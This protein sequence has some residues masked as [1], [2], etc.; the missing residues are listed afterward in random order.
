MRF[1]MI[2]ISRLMAS[3]YPHNVSAVIKK[4]LEKSL[5]EGM[6]FAL[7]YEVADVGCNMVV[8]AFAGKTAEAAFDHAWSQMVAPL[9]RL[10]RLTAKQKFLKIHAGGV[11]IFGFPIP[12]ERE[13]FREGAAFLVGGAE[14]KVFQES[15]SNQAQKVYEAFNQSRVH[16]Y[17]KPSAKVNKSSFNVKWES[18]EQVASE[19]KPLTEIGAYFFFPGSNTSDYLRDVRSVLTLNGHCDPG[20]ADL[21]SKLDYEYFVKGYPG[22]LLIIDA[23]ALEKG[24]AGLADIYCRPT[25]CST[26]SSRALQCLCPADREAYVVATDLPSARAQFLDHRLAG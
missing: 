15:A 18:L 2:S 23:E 21:I 22:D 25:H 11:N 26:H 5:S 4:D 12:V 17:D 19:I 9:N 16:Y 3:G 14:F 20:L 13:R 7:F 1:Q 6:D 8:H 10:V 24:V